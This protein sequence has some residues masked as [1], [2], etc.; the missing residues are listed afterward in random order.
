MDTAPR[1]TG[2]PAN[3]F[4]MGSRVRL[5]DRQQLFGHR[6]LTIWLTG[7]SGAGKSTIAYELEA[8]LVRSGFSAV[9]LDGDNL[10]HGLNRNL[11]FS[12]AERQE[13]IRRVAEVARLMN[14]AGLIVI[15]ACISP[16]CSDREAARG[17]VG[18]HKFAEVY[19]STPLAIC[20]QRDC[21]GLYAKARAGE[22][23]QFTGISA[24]YEA[25]R[26]PVLELDTGALRLDES[27]DMLFRMARHCCSP[28]AEVER[29]DHEYHI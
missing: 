11:G 29:Y 15:S 18:E 6:A 5:V 2:F 25:P 20:E 3:I 8:R 10:R 13:N 19:V 23:A 16:L 7:L 28:L 4:K 9:V 17:I 26:N 1:Q 12:A 27:V 22:L 24:P 21:K 14:D